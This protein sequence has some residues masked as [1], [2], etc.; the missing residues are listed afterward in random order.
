MRVLHRS[1][2]PSLIEGTSVQDTHLYK[3]KNGGP[4]L[5]E[6]TNFT[7][8]SLEPKKIS[9]KSRSDRLPF[10]PND[11]E[12][13]AQ[14]RLQRF[15]Q[16]AKSFALR[17]RQRGLYS[18]A[19]RGRRCSQT[20]GPLRL[21][22]GERDRCHRFQTFRHAVPVADSV[23]TRPTVP[24]MA[25]GPFRVAQRPIALPQR[26]GDCGNAPGAP[27]C[28]PQFET[29]LQL[30]SRFIEPLLIDLDTADGALY[31]RLK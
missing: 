7:F 6:K 10:A 22:L 31:Q 15:L 18:R 26:A 20:G 17:V 25:D 11:I 2:A 29:H 3:P 8:S 14:R 24:K 4:V 12:A 23:P 28:I 30:R 9:D 1:G 13:V 27:D 19:Q 5:K 21:L 16:S